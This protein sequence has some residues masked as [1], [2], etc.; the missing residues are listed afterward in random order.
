[1]IDFLVS[2][3]GLVEV[4]AH[5]DDGRVHHCEL[6]RPLGG[7]LMVGS[8]SEDEDSWRIEPGTCG[9]YIVAERVDELF[10]RA[11]Q[12]GAT[13][14]RGPNDT[15]SGSREFTVRDTEGSWWSFATCSGA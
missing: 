9:T 13:V 11:V 6:A 14:V 7:G 10:E 3:S 15:D 1:M 4:V 12:A 2:A 5:G 8:T